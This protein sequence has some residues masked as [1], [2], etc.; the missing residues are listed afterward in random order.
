MTRARSTLA[1]FL[2]AI[3]TTDSPFLVG[4][5]AAVDAGAAA[6]GNALVTVTWMGT[7]FYATYGSHYTP[8]VGH[9]VLLARTQPPAILQHLIG[10]PP[11]S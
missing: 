1:D 4:Q 11:T 3:G 2:A 6:D 5:V 7:D 9:V 10:T 8:A